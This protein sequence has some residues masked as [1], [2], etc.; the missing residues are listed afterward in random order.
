MKEEKVMD[1]WSKLT[2]LKCKE[3]VYWC[4]VKHTEWHGDMCETCHA[5]QVHDCNMFTAI[6]PQNGAMFCTHWAH[7]NQSFIDG[8]TLQ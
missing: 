5:D 1:K 7:D 2:C 8:G 6:S 3:D 4:E